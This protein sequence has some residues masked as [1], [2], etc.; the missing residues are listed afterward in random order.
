VRWYVTIVPGEHTIVIDGLT[1]DIQAVPSQATVSLSVLA[2]TGAAE[3]TGGELSLN[4]HFT[5]VAGWSAESAPRD[6][7]VQEVLTRLRSIYAQ[8]NIAI[9]EV[10]YLDVDPSY[11]TLREYFPPTDL[12][13]MLTRC[14]PTP[15]QRR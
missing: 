3:P 8:A 7:E 10:R 12:M 5:G 11:A 9:D 15:T 13:M 1:P 4:L 14:A 6:A 2:K